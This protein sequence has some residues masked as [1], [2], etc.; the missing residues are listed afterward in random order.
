MVLYAI[1]KAVMR[2]GRFAGPE[3]HCLFDADELMTLLREGGFR[4]DDIAVRHVN[5]DMGVNGRIAA[6]RKQ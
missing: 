3:T 6:V 5:A 4:Q 2:R 1:D